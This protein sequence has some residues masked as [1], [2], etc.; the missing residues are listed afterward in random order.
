MDNITQRLLVQTASRTFGSFT[1]NQIYEKFIKQEKKKEWKEYK[2]L[3]VE[4]IIKKYGI[5]PGT[6][7]YQVPSIDTRFNKDD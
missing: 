5:I 1:Q 7:K 3:I 4:D 6:G 2:N